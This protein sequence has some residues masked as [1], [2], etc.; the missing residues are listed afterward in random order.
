MLK[1][2]NGE[3]GAMETPIGNLP[4]SADLNMDGLNLDA[5]RVEEL[6]GLDRDGWKRELAEVG[7]YLDSY[8]ART[9]AALK[10][11]QQRVA[12]ALAN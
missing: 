5:A 10:A 12:A 9:P 1:R 11:E 7:A 8:G 2:V 4:N 3:A 6:L